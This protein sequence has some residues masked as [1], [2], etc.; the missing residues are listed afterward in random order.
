[1]NEAVTPARL[2]CPRCRSRLEVFEMQSGARTVSAITLGPSV[3]RH[4]KALERFQPA[5]ERPDVVCPVCQ[6]KF[7]PA[8]P[9]RSGL[10]GPK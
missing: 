10:S 3:E 1:M 8:S 4:A 6:T 7:D 9:Y 2:T 5:E